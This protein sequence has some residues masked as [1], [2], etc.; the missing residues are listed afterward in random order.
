MSFSQT[1]K[2]LVSVLIPVYNGTEFLDQAIQSVLN[3][4]YKRFEIILVDDGS[5]DKSRKKCL[6]YAEKYKQVSFYGFRKNKGMT[7]CLNFG[8]KKA[9]GKY[10]ARFNQD[11]IMMKDRLEKQVKFLEAHPDYVI[12][13]GAIRLFTEHNPEYDVLKFPKTDN[14]IRSQWMILSPYSDPTVM[15]RK[16]TWLQTDGYSQYFWPADDVH[17]WYQLG[18]LGKMANIQSVLTL[19]RWH[20][21]CGSI[22][23][24][25]RQ[26]IKTWAV[27]QWANECVQSATFSEKMFW[28]AELVAGNLFPA[29][30][31]WWVYRV[32]RHIQVLQIRIQN[33]LNSLAKAWGQWNLRSSL[34]LEK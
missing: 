1:K 9:R 29:Q 2:P 25:R 24:H 4:T 18:S 21:D 33:D 26:M 32:I 28:F 12:V 27:H 23:S 34:S 7:R 31:N 14:Q 11:D 5:T 30:F 17:M 10:I 13:G 8:V 22:K 19:V 20:S 3:S 6:E 16:E 15:Y